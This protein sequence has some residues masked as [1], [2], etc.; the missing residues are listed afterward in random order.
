MW[1]E[2]SNQPGAWH[3][4]A[5]AQFVSLGTFRKNGELVE[6]P[7][8]IAADGDTLV[9][10]TDVATGKV[11]RLRRDDR[12]VMRTCTRL[13]AVHPDSPTVSARG[14]IAGP[15]REHPAAAASLRRKYGFQ[16]I[17]FLMVERLVRR[18]RGKPGERV[19]LR[20]SPA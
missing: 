7:I 3:H 6:T 20:F 17:A 13:G 5:E 19:I 8:W 2:N 14:V 11:K 1:N 10:T 16:V 4:M 12:V 18:L 9:V 15:H